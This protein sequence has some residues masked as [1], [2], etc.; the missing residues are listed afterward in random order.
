MTFQVRRGR[1]SAGVAAL[2]DRVR[3]VLLAALAALAFATMD[4]LVK[5]SVQTLPVALIGTVRYVI[6]ISVLLAV[7]RASTG[8]FRKLQSSSVWLQLVRGLFLLGSTITFWVALGLLPLPEAVA[9]AAL[10]PVIA[11]V[12]AIPVLGE[13]P[14]PRQRLAVVIGTV[15]ALLVVQP[16]TAVFTPAAFLA[17][18]TAACYASFEVATRRLGSRDSALSTL[19]HTG[20]VGLV[21]MTLGL[22]LGPI[23]AVGGTLLVVLVGISM[24]GLAG[25][26]LIIR[27]LQLAP[28]PQVTPVSYTGL[29][30][31]VVYGVVLFGQVPNAIAALGMAIIVGGG[32]LLVE[33]FPAREPTLP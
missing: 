31:G 16:G 9:L 2:D 18:G 24:C 11:T 25:H 32:L 3:A 23:P 26:Y 28:V 29:L 6:Q 19:F 1:A 12:L 13:H 22:S 15:G 27:A 17:I 10:S 8:S 5:L 7:V 20:L 33:Q 14:R 4:A 30:W 21:A